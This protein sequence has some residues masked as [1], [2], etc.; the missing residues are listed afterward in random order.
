ME[1]ESFKI[2]SDTAYWCIKEDRADRPYIY[3][4]V[5]RLEKALEHQWKHDNPVLKHTSPI[6][7]KGLIGSV[8]PR[9]LGQRVRRSVSLKLPM[10][11]RDLHP[12]LPPPTL[13]MDKL[14]A[15]LMN[16]VG[17]CYLSAL[18][19][20]FFFT[21]VLV[22]FLAVLSMDDVNAAS[23]MDRNVVSKGDPFLMISVPLIRRSPPLAVRQPILEKTAAQRIACRGEGSRAPWKKRARKA[24]DTVALGIDG[25][26]VGGLR[27]SNVEKE[28]VELSEN[29]VVSLP[30]IT[31][32]QLSAH[33]EHDDTKENPIPF[34]LVVTKETMKTLMLIALCQ[35]GGFVMTSL[36]APTLVRRAYQSLG[37]GV[38]A[39]GELLKRHE[40]LNKEYVDLCNRNDAQLK[41]LNRLRNDL[42]GPIAGGR[43]TK[44]VA[45]LAQAEMERHKLIREFIPEARGLSLGKTKDD[46]ADVLSETSNLDIEGSRKWKD[47]HCELFTMQFPYVRK[48][49][50]SYRL[51]VEA[52]MKLYPD[53]PPVDANAEAGPS[54]E[55]NDGGSTTQVPP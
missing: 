30:H 43:E 35:I 6:Q 26:V 9:C 8:L 38:L 44:L 11:R 34:I 24:K 5:K 40:Q 3:Q 1:P 13:T 28:V 33:A 53:V 27:P 10:L 19:F 51:L 49:A 18:H 52:L 46:I 4:V 20:V 14:P 7:L 22:F 37:Q 15:R 31:K 50:D 16:V 2:F 25:D 12:R 42:D 41:K 23:N 55:N 39:Y 45:E 17:S 21:L 48:I 29:I 32:I 54:T 47:K 36:S